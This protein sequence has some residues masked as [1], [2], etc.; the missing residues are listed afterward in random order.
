MDSIDELGGMNSI[1]M[2]RHNYM[3]LFTLFLSIPAGIYWWPE[4]QP[5]HFFLFIFLYVLSALGVTIGYHRYFTHHS[6]ECKPWLAY[7]FLILGSVSATGPLLQW[8]RTHLC[9]HHFADQPTDPHSPVQSNFWHAHIGWYLTDSKPNKDIE[10][11]DQKLLDRVGNS[12]IAQLGLP[13]YSILLMGI[14]IPGII[15]GLWTQSLMGA[16]LGVLWGGLLRI[17]F[18]FNM[19]SS[20]DS[21]CHL[22]GK[23]TYDTKDNSRD[24]WLFGILALGEGWHNSHHKFPYSSRHG[25]KWWQIDISYYVIYLLEKCGI[26]WD[27]KLPANN[28]SHSGI[29]NE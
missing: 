25:L 29:N 14:L 9:H 22:F 21:L 11:Q 12:R 3:I 5:I 27:V 19:E 20:I 24:N 1:G 10:L 4:A 26:V 15:A 28:L 16:W 17:F 23:R 18:G 13:Y 6:F 8:V 7:S 2:Q